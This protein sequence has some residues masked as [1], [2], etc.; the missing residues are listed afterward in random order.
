MKNKHWICDTCGRLHGRYIAGV[1]TFHAAKCD[2]CGEKGYVTE[3]RDYGLFEG[4]EIGEVEA[5]AKIL[6]IK[7]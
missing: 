6:G 7:K 5:L 3:G 4:K 1:S 2:W